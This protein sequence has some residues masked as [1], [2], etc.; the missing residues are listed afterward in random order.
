VKAVFHAVDLVSTWT[1][2]AVSWFCVAL[3]LVITYDV[4]KRYLFGGAT[5]WVYE[6]ATMLGATIYVMGWA[7]IQRL[8]EHIRVD[9]LFVR[10]PPKIRLVLDLIANLLFL[11]PLLAV[12][13]NTSIFYMLRAWRINEKLAETFWYPP[14]GPFK[15]ML[16]IALSLFALQTLV[17]FIRDIYLL[18]GGR[19]P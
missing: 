1:A 18:K 15:T 7:Y 12:M 6:T 2:K 17:Q 11:L 19:A 14:A 3:V 5:I 16:V 10:L 4:A 13:I 9:I 8:G